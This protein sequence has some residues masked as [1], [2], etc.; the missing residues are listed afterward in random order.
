M[1]TRPSAFSVAVL[2]ISHAVHDSYL[3][4]LAV[5]MPLLIPHLGISLGQAGI[6]VAIFSMTSALGQPLSGYITDQTG[7]LGFTALALPLTAVAM[8]V[9]G[10]LKSPVTLGL[11]VAV[12]GLSS[13]IYHPQ[14]AALAS[15]L[16]GN[17]RGLAVAVFMATG[18]LGIAGGPLV[19]LSLV[20][21]WGLSSTYL[22]AIPA[23][24]LTPL[25]FRYV[26]W[27]ERLYTSGTG[28]QLVEALKRSWR[29]LSLVFL[30]VVFRS[31]IVIAITSFMGV[32]LTADRSMAIGMVKWAMFVFLLMEGV[33]GLSGG[34]LSDRLGRKTIITTGL[35]LAIA[36]LL[37]FLWADGVW[38]WLSLG[39]LGVCLSLPMPAL[40]VKAQETVTGGV[41]TASGLMMG[42]GMAAGGILVSGIGYLGDHW[43]LGPAL[44]LTSLLLV[45]S[46]VLALAAPGDAPGTVL[47]PGQAMVTER[48]AGT[49][50]GS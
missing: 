41:A 45:G 17:R 24:V 25:V 36:P 20:E 15:V 28:G 31:S 11:A 50:T 21:R 9:I 48:T 27:R 4:F 32:Y 26:P 7:W 35:L 43:G 22:A 39:L 29:S 19:I 14:G 34:Y 12:G 13:A 5:L 47:S 1:Q 30:I 46:V 10:L 42:A 49:G 16:G 33:G 37:G 38:M 44:A 8:S 3:V 18:V 6:L 23:L 40:I 2:G